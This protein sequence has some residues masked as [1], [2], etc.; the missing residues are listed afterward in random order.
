MVTPLSNVIT[1]MVMSVLWVNC[2]TADFYD[3][4]KLN[5]VTREGYNVI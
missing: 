3:G 5:I 2:V 1:V 4:M